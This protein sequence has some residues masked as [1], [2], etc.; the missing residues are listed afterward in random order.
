MIRMPLCKCLNFNWIRL[1]GKAGMGLRGHPAATTASDTA[2]AREAGSRNEAKIR[3]LT[4][5][6]AGIPETGRF[7]CRTRDAEQSQ[8]RIRTTADSLLSTVYNGGVE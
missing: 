2:K 3:R 1:S 7:G 6:D 5:G 8:I 4:A